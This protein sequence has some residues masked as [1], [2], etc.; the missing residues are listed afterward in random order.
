MKAFYLFI[1]FFSISIGSFSQSKKEIKEAGIKSKTEKT[2]I[3]EK[4]KSVTF[5]ESIEK[6]DADGNVIELIEYEENGDTK[7]HIVYSYNEKGKLIKESKINPITKKEKSYI[8]YVYGEK[9]K[10]VKQTEYRNNKLYTT[11]EY[12][13]EG[14]F[15]TL[16]RV[17]NSKNK[18]IE[19]K[20]YTYEK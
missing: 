18:L 15:K 7:K 6:Y 10:L 20:I 1:I 9:N 5:T 11:T 3:T 13:Y 17:F 16:K 19:S 14:E 12:S 8:E 4:G 2:Q